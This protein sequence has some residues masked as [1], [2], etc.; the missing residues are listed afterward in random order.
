MKYNLAKRWD[1]HD[2]MH[3]NVVPS[4][5]VAHTKHSIQVNWNDTIELEAL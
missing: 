4:L 3:M 2:P 1:Q 5:R